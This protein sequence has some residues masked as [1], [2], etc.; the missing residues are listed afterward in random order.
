VKKT[1][2]V[3]VKPSLVNNVKFNYAKKAPKAKRG[4]LMKNAASS[5][6]APAASNGASL[7]VEDLVAVK[8]LVNRLGKDSLAKLVDVL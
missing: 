3:E 5:Q 4:R 2:R 1:H 6:P 8:E 7:A